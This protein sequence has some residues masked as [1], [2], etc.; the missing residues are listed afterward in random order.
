MC[1]F[2]IQ[3]GPFALNKNFS[4]KT[5]NVNFIYLLAL[6]LVQKFKKILRENPDLW[7]CAIFGSKMDHLPQT[8]I[9][10]EKILNIIF[11]YLLAPFIVHNFKKFLLWIQSYEDALFFWTQNRPFTQTRIFSEIPLIKVQKACFWP[12]SYQFCVTCSCSGFF[13][14]I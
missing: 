14:N 13:Q 9:F 3:N 10:L 7:G 12:I 4:V 2:W 5:I 6:F 8:R 11:I 1:H